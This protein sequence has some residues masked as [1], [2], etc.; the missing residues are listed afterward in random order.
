MVRLKANRLHSLG[1]TAKKGCRAIANK[2]TMDSKTSAVKCCFLL[3][4]GA[5]EFKLFRVICLEETVCLR[6]FDV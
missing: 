6:I 4:D 5:V 3:R 1:L 2:V